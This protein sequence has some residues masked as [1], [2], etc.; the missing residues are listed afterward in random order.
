MEEVYFAL[1]CSGSNQQVSSTNAILSRIDFSPDSSLWKRAFMM[2][3]C[4]LVRLVSH[5]GIYLP[6]TCR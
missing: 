2:Y 5:D 6:A 4:S 3:G 1:Y